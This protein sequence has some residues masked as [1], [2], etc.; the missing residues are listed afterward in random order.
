MIDT[1]LV[2]IFWACRYP[3]TTTLKL[4][5]RKKNQRRKGLTHRATRL[6]RSQTMARVRGL[7]SD[8]KGRGEV[9][10]HL[11]RRPAEQRTGV[12]SSP[13][14]RCNAHLSTLGCTRNS[15]V[16]IHGRR[17]RLPR[18]KRGGERSISKT[19]QVGR[20]EIIQAG[21]ENG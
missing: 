11:E 8:P 13:I 19:Y 21:W 2:R 9:S 12:P 16:S 3:H 6:A 18:H 1:V 14:G 17:I 5:I 20:L 7:R 4:N 10:I 15:W